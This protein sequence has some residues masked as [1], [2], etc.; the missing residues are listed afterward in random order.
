M[1]LPVRPGLLFVNEKRRAL[2]QSAEQ[3]AK[4]LPP[5]SKKSLLTAKKKSARCVGTLDFTSKTIRTAELSPCD[6]VCHPLP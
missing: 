5:F 3:T 4:K 6:G 1:L 2:F